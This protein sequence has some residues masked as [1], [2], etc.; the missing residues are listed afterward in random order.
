[1]LIGLRLSSCAVLSSLIKLKIRKDTTEHDVCRA[2]AAAG[3]C[4]DVRLQVSLQ[5]RSVSTSTE[6]DFSYRYHFLVV[7]CHAY[8]APLDCHTIYFLKQIINGQRK[9]LHCDKV[10]YL[11]VPQYEGLGVKQFLSEAAKYPQVAAYLPD[12]DD[13]R[14]LPRQWIIN[15]I[16]TLAGKPF[17][18]WVLEHTEARNRKVVSE[19]KMAIDMDPEIMRAFQAS[20]HVSSKC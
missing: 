9:F 6:A 10:Q 1:M 7:E 20:T 2:A 15:L 17:A 16:Y 11:S 13:W 4:S 12:Q 19:K 3:D 14:K 8:L 18:D 5:A